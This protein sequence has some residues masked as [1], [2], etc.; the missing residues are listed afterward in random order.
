MD[1]IENASTDHHRH[2]IR[3]KTFDYT[4]DGAYFITACTHER[5]CLFGNIID[6]TMTLNSPGQ[7]V[8]DVWSELPRHY[9]HVGLDAFVIMPNHV[10]GIILFL[11]DP[12]GAGFK[13]ALATRS[14]LSEIVR[15]FKTFSSRRINTLRLTPGTAV[16]QRNYY[17]HVARDEDDLQRLRQYI[18]DNPARWADD[19]NNPFWNSSRFQ[20][21]GKSVA[22]RAVLP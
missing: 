15:A 11:S 13:P 17:E 5:E 1:Y 19:E 10:H 21:R 12:V 18:T 20:P 4:Q 16:W 3:L 22:C 8:Q 7:I 9:H 6:G 14:P 2:S